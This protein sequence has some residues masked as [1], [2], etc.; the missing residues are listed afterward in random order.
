MVTDPALHN[1]EGAVDA[2][3]IMAKV[4]R[5]I[6]PFV[7]ICYI[8][9]YIDRVNVG[10]GALTMNRD[11]GLS[12]AQFGFG[13]GVFFFGYF[14]FEIPRNL[15]MTRVG[16]RV[17]IARI[18]ITWGLI[19]MATSMISGPISFAIMRFLLGVGEAGFTPGIYL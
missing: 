4:M 13:A 12:A 10:F 15:T 16:A 8:I 18:M 17:W 14:A 9:S 2:D 19:S 3:R 11:L 6:V 5:R 7:L 1:R